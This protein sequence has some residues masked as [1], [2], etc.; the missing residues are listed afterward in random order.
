MIFNKKKIPFNGALKDTE[1][2]R[3]Y[4]L[5]EIASAGVPIWTEKKEYNHY[6]IR[7][8][9]SSYSCVA[10]SVATL[11]EAMLRKN[12]KE[13]PVSAKPIYLSRTNQ[14]GGM[15]FREAMDI[16]SKNGSTLEYLVPSQNM[17]EEQMNDDSDITMFDIYVSDLLSGMAYI[18]VPFNFNDIAS[19]LDKGNPMIVGFVWDYDEWD[20]EFPKI[21]TNSKRQYHHCFLENNKVLTDGGYIEIKDIKVGDLVMTHKG[22]FRKVKNLIRNEY[23]G[24]IIN[25]KARNSIGEINCTPEH[26]ILKREINKKT[27]HLKNTLL[28]G[29]DKFNWDDA[30]TITEESVF[31]NQVFPNSDVNISEKKAY[32]LGAYIGDGNISNMEK[33]RTKTRFTIGNSKKDGKLEQKII[34]YMFDEF[35][36]SPQIYNV[37]D[38]NCKSIVFHNKE[39]RDFFEKWGGLPNNKEVN[40][41]LLYANNSLLKYFINGWTDTDGSYNKNGYSIFTSKENLAQSLKIILDKLNNYYSIIFRDKRDGIINGRKIYGSGGYDFRI[42][43]NPS[44]KFFKYEFGKQFVRVRS[45]SKNIT[46][47]KGII[48]NLEVEEDNSYVVEGVTVHNCVTIVDYTLINGVKYLVIQDSWGKGRGKNG[49][50]FISEEWLSRMTACWYYELMMFNEIEPDTNQKFEK[51]LEFGMRDPDVTRLQDFLKAQGYFPINT[52]S[53]GYYGSITVKAVRDFQLAKE[54]ISSPEDGGAGRCGPK[55]REVIN[56]INDK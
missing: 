21:N 27:Q 7:D 4:K 23:N 9:S 33:H 10:Q 29:E 48:Y 13:V 35:G 34:Q 6:T 22:R 8:Q 36:C 39:S 56:K 44:N 25:F 17:T 2:V 26:P 54:I 11:L 37:K 42:T 53:T 49:L 43:K 20:R 30:E 15:Y 41:N 51:D 3:D 46:K 47:H 14:G 18:S 45:G 50:R 55:T 40:Y 38:E 52:E 5:E 24:D 12:G 1:D 31:V 32:L 28:Q 16:G 19:V